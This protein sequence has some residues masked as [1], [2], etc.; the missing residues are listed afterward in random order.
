MKLRNQA[1]SLAGALGLVVAGLTP[2]AASAAAQTGDQ[3][4]YHVNLAPL[5]NS[6]VQGNG[7][8]TL[9]GDQ[10][11]VQLYASGFQ[12]N[13]AHPQHIHGNL[14]NSN[15]TCPT[16]A[17]D[18]N[19]DGFVSVF[20]GAA[21]YGPIKVNFT[22]PQ[23]P[24]GPN[25]NTTLFAPFAGVPDNSTF[26]T[27]PNGVIDFNQTY[28]FNP[29]KPFDVQAKA[30]TMPLE[31]QHIVLHGATVP[32]S[33]D[34]PGGDPSKL[35][36]D[37]LIPVACGEIIPIAA[38]GSGTSGNSDNGNAGNGNTGATG[39]GGTVTPVNGGALSGAD[40]FS[41]AFTTASDQFAAAVTQA[42]GSV[43]GAD[44]QAIVQAHFGQAEANLRNTFFTEVQGAMGQFKATLANGGDRNV[45][46]DQ[47]MNRFNAAKDHALG[48]QEELR[49]QLIDQLNRAGVAKDEFVNRFSAAKDKFGGALEQIKNQFSETVNNG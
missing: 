17:Q 33:V 4:I 41:T 34:T 32:E 31:N 35:V 42:E 30:G 40:T 26:P 39:A 24:F 49:N 25:P 38:D 37:P 5:N 19:H 46:K 13:K 27:A 11:N 7:A 29:S 10:L 28:S 20:E 47:F 1:F 23:T 14:D 9:N 43:T 44:G 8:F 3:K 45:A 16:L 36:Y 12:P 6:G 15:A 2:L 48:Q 22:T 21:T 18:T